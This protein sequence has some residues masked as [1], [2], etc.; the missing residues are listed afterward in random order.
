AQRSKKHI[1]NWQENTTQT[2]IRMIKLPN[3]NSRKSM[4]PMK[5]WAILKSAKNTI[6]TAKIGNMEKLTSRPNVSSN[7]KGTISSKAQAVLA[8][9]ISL[10]AISLISLNPCLVAVAQEVVVDLQDLEARI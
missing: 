10:R 1:E 6:R 2:S 8:I 4:R 3:T 9:P 7:L 5:Y